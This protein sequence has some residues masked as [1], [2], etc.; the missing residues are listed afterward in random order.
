[1]RTESYLPWWSHR[2]T[3]VMFAV[4]CFF[5]WSVAL[6]SA[7]AEAGSLVIPAW[8]FDRGNVKIHADPGEY[9]D[10]GPVV[11][12]GP[13]EPWGWSV[14][15]DVDVP[16]EGKYTLSICY[17]SAESRPVQVFFDNRNLAKCCNGISLTSASSEKPNSPTWKSSGARWEVLRN[18]FGA[19]AALAPVKH[20]KAKPGKHTVIL[21]SRTPLPH[22]VTLR[23]DTEKAFPEDWT[24]P[25]YKVRDLDSVPEEF[26]AAFTRPSDV[27]VA[28]LRQPFKLAPDHRPGATLQISAWTFDRGNNAQ[29]YASPDQYADNGPVVGSK[30]DH[31]DDEEAT[32]E[33]DIDFPVDADYTL[34]LSYASADA[35]PM[36]VFV[37]GKSMGMCCVGVTYGSAPYEQPVVFTSNSSGASKRWEGFCEKGK[38]VKMP[39]TKG[40]HTLK[41]SRRG[42]LPN[43]IALRLGS[44]AGFPEGWKPTARKIQHF[45]KV[46]VRDRAVF[47]P[48]GAVNVDGLRASIEDMIKTFG[49]RYPDG[50]KY[51]KRLAELEKSSGTTITIVADESCGQDEFQFS[52]HNSRGSKVAVKV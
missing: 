34:H 13:R 52:C 38:L 4:A 3:R 15:Y 49:P 42:P 21:T 12:S 47:L 6:P 19:P 10:A 11:V 37:D 30:L 20:G 23:L 39:I 46:P 7:P 22:L 28:A 27:D 8:A 14:E 35:R 25:K 40:K 32:I 29:I 1:M 18:R 9:A 5:V 51:L 26:R 24:P 33:Y 43:L 50:E 31:G 36:E 2:L 16:V 17:A 48:A 44:S 45:D 41:F